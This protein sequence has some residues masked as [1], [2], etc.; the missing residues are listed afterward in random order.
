M[1]LLGVSHV[2]DITLLDHL[3]LPVA[4][5]V[6]PGGT[7]VRVHAGKGLSQ[8]D[9]HAGAL[10]EAVEFAACERAG[11]AEAR[12]PWSQVKA[13][14]PDG[15]SVFDF[16]PR[17][18][19]RLRVRAHVPVLA[20]EVLGTRRS[21]W[22]P[23]ELVLLR[24]PQARPPDLFGCTSNGLASGNSLDEATLHALLEVLERDTI[25]LH[26][27]RDTSRSVA[28]TSWPEPFR[29]LSREWQRRGVRLT[30]RWLPNKLDL[31]CFEAS[32]HEAVASDAGLALA[33]GSGLHL[34]RRIAFARAVCEAAQ[35]RLAAILS[36]HPDAPGAAEMAERLGGP[37]PAEKMVALLAR[38]SDVS[39]RARFDDAPH[40]LATT[41]REALQ[42]LRLRMA[43]AGLGPVFRR[44][45]P[46]DNQ[47]AASRGL[48]VVKLVVA[49]SETPIGSH[50]RIGPRLLAR[51]KA[52]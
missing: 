36:R 45:L 50:P 7:T 43:A 13:G 49:R 17:L 47:P 34:D 39:R 19:V 14:W 33:R 25:A 21:A 29:S 37:P 27:A 41:V 8:V 23:A 46:L 40:Q 5:S 42:L 24:T 2:L 16:A 15:L 38:L 28:A 20:C 11:S 30:V 22:L 18:G 35:S 6:R 1:R 12:L 51:L 3:G 44:R 48:H 10:M 4:I 32:L 31:P 9:A 52:S 26:L